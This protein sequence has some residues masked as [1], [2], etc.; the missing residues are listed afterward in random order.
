MVGRVNFLCTTL[1]AKGPYA[2]EHLAVL[3]WSIITT[4]FLLIVS[5]PVLAGGI[6]MILFDRQINSAFFEANGGG[7]PLLYQHLF[8]FF[9]HPEVYVLIL[10]AFGIAAH[11]AVYLRGKKLVFGLLGIVYAI[12]GIG[13]IGCVVW[14]HHM[15]VV[16]IDRDRRAYFTGATMIIAV[17]TGLKV[18]S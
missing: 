10:P 13:F 9:G 12:L 14:A 15:F 8:W 17:P 1:K 11:T 6:T 3:L 2:L 16:G 7:N 4:T 18:Y 5:L